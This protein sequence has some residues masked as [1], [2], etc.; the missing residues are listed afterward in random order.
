MGAEA[1]CIS[2][3][4]DEALKAEMERIAREEGLVPRGIKGNYELQSVNVFYDGDAPKAS[5]KRKKELFKHKTASWG[6]RSS[7]I[8]EKTFQTT[9][10]QH[11]QIEASTKASSRTPR[12]ASDKIFTFIDQGGQG[13]EEAPDVRITKDWRV[14]FSNGASY[15]GQWMNG[16]KDGRGI[17]VWSN[18]AWRYEGTFK[19]DMKHGMGTLTFS[20]GD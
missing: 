15:Q 7:E 10:D 4:S 9:Y 12:V 17:L 16:K 20:N 2:G 19:N 18:G 1:C 5:S 13:E 8:F 14:Q 6:R 11:E 3:S